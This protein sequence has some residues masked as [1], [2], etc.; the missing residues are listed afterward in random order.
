MTETRFP[1]KLHE[2]EQEFAALA[3]E[4]P[5]SPEKRALSLLHGIVMEVRR[6]LERERSADEGGLTLRDVADL[7]QSA[8]AMEGEA[9][10][11]PLAPGTVAPDFALPDASGRLVRL[12]DFRGQPVVLVFYPLDW[13]PGC[14]R[15]LDLY[16]QELD[17]FRKRNAQ[18]LAVSVDSIYSHG[19]WAA[20][21]GLEFPLLADFEPKGAVAKQYGAYRDEDGFS[22]RAL[23]VIDPEGVIRYSHVSPYLHHVPDL[24]ELLEAID[25]PRLAAVA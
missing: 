12:S 3:D 19:A 20:V 10:N 4:I 8:R 14:S 1:R 9:V 6:D 23:C 18:I 24:D 5:E 7:W 22:E 11:T 15:Q 16:Q 17:E 2:L 21:R 25:E 13:S